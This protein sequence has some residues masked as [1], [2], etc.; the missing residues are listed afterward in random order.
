[1]LQTAFDPQMHGFA[2]A[3]TFTFDGAERRHLHQTFARCLPWGGLLGAVLLGLIGAFLPPF[4]IVGAA[5]F[6]LVGVIL[7]ALGILALRKLLERH[8]APHYGLCGGMCFTALDFYR[9]SRPIPRDQEANGRPAPGAPL[10]RYIWK[11]Q[12]DSIVSDGAR[13]LAWLIILNHVHPAWPFKGGPAWLLARS[14]KEWQKLKASIDT[15][16][17]IPIGLVRATK[18]VYDNHQVLA[19]G[20]DEVGEARGMIY[21]YDPNCPNRKSTIHIQFGEQL[22]DGQESCG[23][24]APLRGFFCEV[25]SERLP[26]GRPSSRAV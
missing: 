21:L 22:L 15:G 9:A 23:E 6:G 19:I 3:N 17:P 2:F 13:F 14:R 5:V 18:H 7:A 11:R 20:Y 26:R 12:I 10:H 1:M 4:G 24:A 8:L 16:D 25:Y